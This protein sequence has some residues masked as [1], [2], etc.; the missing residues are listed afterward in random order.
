MYVV[1]IFF[2]KYSVLDWTICIMVDI[3]QL[4]PMIRIGNDIHGRFPVILPSMNLEIINKKVRLNPKLME[5]NNV[6]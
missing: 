5:W 1:Y 3:K 6:F 4:T 2:I